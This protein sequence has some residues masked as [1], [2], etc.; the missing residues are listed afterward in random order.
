MITSAA[1]LVLAVSACTYPSAEPG[2]ASPDGTI[3]LAMIEPDDGVKPVTAFIESAKSTLDISMYEFDPTYA[4]VINAIKRVQQRGVKVRVLLSRQLFQAPTPNHNVAD[5]A[6]LNSLGIETALS[7]PEFSYS[8]EKAF[9]ADA[10]T[11]SARVLIADF[12]IGATY[13]EPFVS[14]D[15]ATEGGTR[16]MGVIDT[17]PADIAIIAATFNS[18]WPPYIQWPQSQQPN[19]LWS[20]SSPIYNPRGNSFVKLSNLIYSADRTL[21]IYAQQF[22]EPAELINPVIAQAQVGVRVRLITNTG[23]V[24]DEVAAKLRAAGASVVRNPAM[25]TDPGKHLYI[26]TKTIITDAGTDDAVAFVGSENP[27]LDESIETERELGAL[28][29]DA[30]SLKRIDEVFN[31]DFQN[32]VPY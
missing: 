1:A 28:V 12:N 22:E 29:T 23:V 15:D 10:A 27:F 9:I 3:S 21:D 25:P 17:S 16:G 4:P 26:H 5:A 24:T 6:T 31:R 13:F 11:T 20:P 32:S 19:L 7:R 8:H 14:P 30:A 2:G 18:D